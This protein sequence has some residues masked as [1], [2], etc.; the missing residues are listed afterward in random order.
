MGNCVGIEVG[1][2]IYE[3]GTFDK[4][5]VWKVGNPGTAV[6]L[7]DYTASM[8]VRRKMTDST[9]LISI[10]GSSGTAAPDGTSGIYINPD[11]T[12]TNAGKFNVYIKDEDT[13]GICV[14]HKDLA[15]VYD[16]FLY[17]SDG[18]AVLKM[19][20]EASIKAAATRDV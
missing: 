18:E 19:Y 13:E 3:G 4:Q 16:L 1:I 20:G 7:T 2:V 10:T 17:S 6:D 14:N 5:Y 12:G 8:M 9:A 11:Q 15:A